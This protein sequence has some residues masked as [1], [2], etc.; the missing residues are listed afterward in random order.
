MLTGGPNTLRAHPRR[1]LALALATALALSVLAWEAPTGRAA[2]PE[3]LLG[4]GSVGEFQGVRGDDFIAWQQNTR[5]DPGQYDVYAQPI[6]GGGRFKVNARG[7]SAANG[8]IEGDLLVYQ[9]FEGDRSDLW[10]F[11]LTARS[12]SAPPRGVNTPQWEYWPSISGQHLLFGRLSGNGN[13]R[14][15]LFELDTGDSR[16]LDKLRGAGSFLAPGQ[17]NGDWATWSRCPADGRC[18]VIRYRISSG[19]EETLP[20]PGREQKASSIAPDGTVYFARAKGACGRGVRLISFPLGGPE[21]EMWRLP[22]GDDIG[23]THIY[24]DPDGELTVYFDHYDCDQAAVSDVWEMVESGAVRLSV[25]VQGNGRVTGPGI[26]CGS[27]CTESYDVGTVVTLT[28]TAEATSSFTGWTGACTGSGTSCTVTMSEARSVTATFGA[29]PSL[30]VSK[31]GTGTVTSSPAGISCGNDCTETY[32][33]GT[34][35][36][37]TAD[38]SNGSTFA[39]WSG[40]CSGTNPTCQVTMDA[41]KA[42]TA[43]F[44]ATPRVTLDVEK[45][46]SGSGTVTG[47]GINCGGNC[48]ETYD[49]G[50]VVTLTADAAN[51]S[52]F[53]GWSANCPPTTPTS[54]QVTMDV[55]KTVTATFDVTPGRSV[56]SALG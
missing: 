12:R 15:V 53:I 49:V 9:E 39:G 37:L 11:D 44:V 42:V 19:T 34:V 43:T 46:G 38:P 35:V 16:V 32:P 55:S 27:D 33:A 6:A 20:N 21:T 5:K 13:R 26:D 36:T 51:G 2:T 52:T 41:S 18:D 31:S 25:D 50:T 47:P 56:R 24:V 22:S 10:F 54:C 4:R 8:G 48:S 30:T 17:V 14:I 45:L 1:L 23:S 28:A 29:R 7:T 3:V 40:A